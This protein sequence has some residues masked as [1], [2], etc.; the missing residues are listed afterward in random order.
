MWGGGGGRGGDYI[1]V[2]FCCIGPL[3]PGALV[4]LVCR[5]G[6]RRLGEGRLRWRVTTRL[7]PDFCSY[8]V[9]RNASVTVAWRELLVACRDLPISLFFF[10]FIKRFGF[11][12]TEKVKCRNA[13]LSNEIRYS[14]VYVHSLTK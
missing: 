1:F 14:Y 6:L 4:W 3:L 5:Q 9:S 11:S 10:F 12:E 7:P 13:R 2:G 8:F